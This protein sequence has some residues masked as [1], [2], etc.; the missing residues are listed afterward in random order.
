MSQPFF[1]ERDKQQLTTKRR[2]NIFINNFCDRL[3]RYR[4]DYSLLFLAALKDNE[5]RDSAYTELLRHI[6]VFVHVHFI[7]AGFAVIFLRDRLDRRRDHTARPAPF[8]PK[9][10][11]DRLFRSQNI[12]LKSCICY[13]FCKLSH[14][15][16]Y[17]IPKN[18]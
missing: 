17:E 4:S 1:L 16:S 5:R 14:F 10:D 11:Q 13:F 3:T 2:L 7:N 9:I 18:Y 6:Y 12:R 15:F 8:G